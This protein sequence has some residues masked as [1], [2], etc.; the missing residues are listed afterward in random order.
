MEILKKKGLKDVVKKNEHLNIEKL[1]KY[2]KLSN[3][4]VSDFLHTPNKTLL[5]LIQTTDSPINT[6]NNPS[7]ADWIN[8]MKEN[9]N[10]T[11]S[12]QDIDFGNSII[13]NNY[14]KFI[15]KVVHSVLSI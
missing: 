14:N 9:L 2:L 3:D 15:E 4:N 10:I 12:N 6:D 5:Y 11:T 8:F 7:R 13:Y 1:N